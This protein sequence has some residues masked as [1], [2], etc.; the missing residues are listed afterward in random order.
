MFV[1]TIKFTLI[2]SKFLLFGINGRLFTAS[3][4]HAPQVSS[5]S[6]PARF[7]SVGPSRQ[8]ESGILIQNFL[9]FDSFKKVTFE[10][11]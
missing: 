2:I 8:P 1:Y 6:Y 3:G 9:L 4:S 11:G 10:I 5:L 7:L